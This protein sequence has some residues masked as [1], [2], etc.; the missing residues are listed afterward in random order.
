MKCEI[1]KDLLPSYIDELTSNESNKEIENHIKTCS[2]CRAELESMKQDIHI[3]ELESNKKDIQPLK[4]FNKKYR[5]IFR[6]I[7]ILSFIAYL[8]ASNYTRSSFDKVYS[9]KDSISTK[10]QR[11]SLDNDTDN[12]SSYSNELEK[13]LNQNCKNVISL[14]LYTNN[15]KKT[16]YT[17]KNK[18]YTDAVSTNLNGDILNKN[19]KVIANYSVNI[20]YKPVIIGNNA[21]HYSILVGGI[22]L[23]TYIILLLKSKF[24]SI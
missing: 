22:S 21:L 10:L 20:D 5:N 3:D 6:N 16:V 18:S 4:K 2:K 17:Y 12:I 23:I 14:E 19:K 1:I 24:K 8:I 9:T 15:Y 11:I 13:F 7:A